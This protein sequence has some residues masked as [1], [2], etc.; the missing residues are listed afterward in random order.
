LQQIARAPCEFEDVLTYNGQPITN[1][2]PFG[3]TACEWMPD[4]TQGPWLM[5]NYVT[6]TSPPQPSKYMF[7][8]NRTMQIQ[9]YLENVAHIYTRVQNQCGWSDIKVIEYFWG[10]DC[11]LSDVNIIFIYSPNPI[12]DILT[13]DFE[14]PSTEENR[15]ENI[16]IKLL[17]NLGRVQRKTQ[18]SHNRRNAKPQPIKF[19]VSNLREGTYYLHIENGGQIRKEQIIIKRK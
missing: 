2:N 7:G 12:N 13:I 16:S 5:C 14:I 15:V 17:D 8:A 4:Q 6:L 18:F 11:P 10:L 19:N 3:I 1:T 9:C